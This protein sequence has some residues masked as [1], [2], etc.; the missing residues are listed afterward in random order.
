M[1]RKLKKPESK[2]ILLPNVLLDSGDQEF[3][4]N[5]K[6][7]DWPKRKQLAEPESKPKLPN[8]W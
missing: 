8:E 1:N 2:P 7:N 5:S 4:Q 3:K 6:Q